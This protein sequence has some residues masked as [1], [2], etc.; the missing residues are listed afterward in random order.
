M[1]KNR[2]RILDLTPDKPVKMRLSVLSVVLW[3]AQIFLMSIG[4][5]VVL[6]WFVQLEVF[7]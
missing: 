6:N 2:Y 4:L 1:M 7:K 5:V 3:F